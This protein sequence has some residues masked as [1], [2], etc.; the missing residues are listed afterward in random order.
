MRNRVAE[1]HVTL[2]TEPEIGA[3]ITKGEAA[4]NVAF[5]AEIKR[6]V[7]RHSNGLASVC[8]HLC[9]NMCDAA[10]IIETVDGLP[11]QLT[12]EHFERA[13]KTYVEEA[14]DSIKSAFDKALKQRR[15]TRVR[16]R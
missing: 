7:A 1:I 12:T 5:S 13:V 3:I 16:Q 2:M 6:L 14:S 10:G 15:K 8:H 4:L 11:M 9:L